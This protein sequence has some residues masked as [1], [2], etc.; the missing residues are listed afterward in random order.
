[1]PRYMIETA[2]TTEQCLQTLD[3]MAA[4]GSLLWQCT[5]G[6]PDDHRGWVVLDG[7]S[8]D[9]ARSQMPAVMRDGASVVQVRQFTAAQI[10]AMH[11]A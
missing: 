10:A 11:A 9:E 2:H 4:Q 5:W 8:A 1:M 3:E 6:C 7:A